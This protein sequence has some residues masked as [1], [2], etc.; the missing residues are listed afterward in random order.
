MDIEGDEL[1]ALKSVPF[2]ELHFKIM[3]VETNHPINRSV[4]NKAF[5]ESQGYQYVKNIAV[6]MVFV[7]RHVNRLLCLNGRICPVI[8]R[9]LSLKVICEKVKFSNCDFCISFRDCSR[10]YL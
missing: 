10:T 1:Y 2:D 5:M 4:E 7:E 6:D 8:W 9:E 3:T